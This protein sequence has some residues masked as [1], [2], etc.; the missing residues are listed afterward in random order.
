MELAWTIVDSHVARVLVACTP[1]GVCAVLLG[2]CDD[3]LVHQLRG[4]FPQSS[5]IRDKTA[6]ETWTDD[7]I[8]HVQDT[9]PF[10]HVPLDHQCTPMDLRVREA[11]CQIP[12]GQTRTYGQIASLIGMPRAARAVG[13]ACA[14]NTLAVMVPCH[15][16]LPKAGGL[17][18]YRWGA[19][20]KAFLLAREAKPPAQRR[21]MAYSSWSM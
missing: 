10:P 16:V 8:N 14:R 21:P 11:L 19:R 20:R 18:G 1:K 6:V 9:P 13:R 2:E 17:G 5:L 7:V 3:E 4:A 12:R 15:R